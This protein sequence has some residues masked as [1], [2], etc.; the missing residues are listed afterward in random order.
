MPSV[1]R[2][3]RHP[4]HQTHATEGLPTRVDEPFLARTLVDIP[5]SSIEEG[6]E[7]KSGLEIKIALGNYRMF[8]T[9]DTEDYFHRKRTSAE[10]VDQDTKETE[11]AA[12]AKKRLEEWVGKKTGITSAME[13]E[14]PAVASA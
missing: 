10:L 1:I 7:T 13:V 5:E 2:V 9:P 8:Y 4:D 14:P 3:G 11:E 6:F 12:A